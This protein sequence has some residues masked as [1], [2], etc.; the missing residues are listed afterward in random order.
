MSEIKPK[1]P[2]CVA[3]MCGEVDCG[4]PGPCYVELPLKRVWKPLDV[5]GLRLYEVL[6]TYPSA[7]QP[8]R[9]VVAASAPRDAV[10]YVDRCFAG[11]EPQPATAGFA[12]NVL[13]PAEWWENGVPSDALT[14]Q[15]LAQMG[16]L[17]AALHMEGIELERREQSTVFDI[18]TE[19]GVHRLTEVLEKLAWMRELS[20][21]GPEPKEET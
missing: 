17:R 21:A 12:L 7:R 14:P 2:D 1:H 18:A 13:Q 20:R 10:R 19:T 16:L 4:K 8:T 6:A 9:Y 5:G 3:L 15:Q 11:V